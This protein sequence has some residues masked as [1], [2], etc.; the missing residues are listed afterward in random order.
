MNGMYNFQVNTKTRGNGSL[1]VSITGPRPRTVQETGVTYTG[2]DIYEV[3]FEVS[4]PGYYIINVKWS[5]Y[6]I[7]ESPFICKVTY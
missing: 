5:D 1:N 2:D 3:L 6:N 4:Q 7:P